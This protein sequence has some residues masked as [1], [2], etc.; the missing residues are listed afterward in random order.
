[1]TEISV[2]TIAE[3]MYQMVAESEGKRNLKPGDLIKAMT[4]STVMNVRKD[5]QAGNPA[6]DRIQPLRIQLPWRLLYPVA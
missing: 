1:M 3:E 5:V 4:K 2:E 6:T